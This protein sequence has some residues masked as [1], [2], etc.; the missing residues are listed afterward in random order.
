MVWREQSAHGKGGLCNIILRWRINL[1]KN[2]GPNTFTDWNY[3]AGKWVCKFMIIHVVRVLI[4]LMMEAVSISET[5]VN[6]YQTTRRNVPLSKNN[7]VW[8]GAF[9]ATK[10]YKI[11]S[12]YQPC[13]VVKRRKKN[14]F[15]RTT[16]V[17][18]VLKCPYCPRFEPRTSRIL[19]VKDYT[20]EPPQL[21][22]V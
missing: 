14:N 13:K 4:T 16:S 7:G 5:S 10:F 3:C 21:S 6:F 20:I 22:H 19:R 15:S 1:I 9:T 12:G 18:W 11:L 17:L 8:S 2:E